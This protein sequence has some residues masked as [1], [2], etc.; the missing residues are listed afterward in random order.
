MPEASINYRHVQSYGTAKQWGSPRLQGHL[1][2]QTSVSLQVPV[3]LA[4]S[5]CAHHAGGNHAVI[6]LSGANL[7]LQFE[8]CRAVLDMVRSILDDLGAEVTGIVSPVSICMAFTVALVRILNPEGVADPTAVAIANVYYHEQVSA[9]QLSLQHAPGL[10]PRQY[11][12]YQHFRLQ[13]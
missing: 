1:F 11:A 10:P 7:G 9:W 13:R 4:R 3:C 6:A 2:R 8:P 5:R 12:F